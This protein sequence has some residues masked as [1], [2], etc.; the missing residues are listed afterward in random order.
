MC[1]RTPSEK[2]PMLG[3][4]GASR[5]DFIVQGAP[6]FIGLGMSETFGPYSWGRELPD[7][8]RPLC[9]P[10]VGFEPGYDI[11]VIDADG[12]VVPEG[13]IGEIAL[14]GPTVTVGL[15]KVDFASTF[16]A[17]GFFRTGDRAE[18]GAGT[19]YFIGRLGDMIKVSVVNVSPAEVEPDSSA[20]MA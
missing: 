14:R 19:L 6:M 3:S 13:G 18:V 16:D 8:A 9:P 5:P 12:N 1:R 15:Y 17:D 11:K 7:P 4:V 20:S 10:L 2:G